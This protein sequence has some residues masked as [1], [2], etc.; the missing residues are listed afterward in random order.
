MKKSKQSYKKKSSEKVKE[1]INRLTEGMKKRISNHFHSPEQ[2]KDYLDFMGKF[3]RYSP[4]NTA[5]I[6]SQFPGAEAV[7]SYAF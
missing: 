4:C 3:H 7:G 2:R 1:E 5:L 6:D